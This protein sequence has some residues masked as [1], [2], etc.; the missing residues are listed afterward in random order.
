MQANSLYEFPPQAHKAYCGNYFVLGSSLLAPV[1]SMLVLLALPYLFLP[2]SLLNLESKA[3]L[4]V[5][6]GQIYLTTGCTFLFFRAAFTDP[7]LIPKMSISPN[8]LLRSNNRLALT[9]SPAKQALVRVTHLGV[10][11]KLKYCYTCHII[12]PPR[13]SHCHI[14]NS[15][16]NKFDHHCPWLGTCIARRNY[17]SYYLLILHLFF[18]TMFDVSIALYHITLCARTDEWEETWCS[19]LIIPFSL[20][21]GAFSGKLFVLH[22]LM[23]MSNRTSKEVVYGMF[24]NKKLNPNYQERKCDNCAQAFR[25]VHSR[26]KKKRVVSK[27]AI[28]PVNETRRELES[29]RD[30]QSVRITETL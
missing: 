13:V 16:F 28:F 29:N 30:G 8:Q 1:L 19:W 17:K 11:T 22:T 25:N 12:R 7:G 26:L 9:S 15:C 24:K 23:I 10:V 14:C 4:W 5:I 3:Q 20:F 2:F 6:L 18:L 21:F 27:L